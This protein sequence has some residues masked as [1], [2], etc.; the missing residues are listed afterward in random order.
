[1]QYIR[2][3]RNINDHFPSD[4]ENYNLSVKEL[5]D[6]LLPL[7]FVDLHVETKNN[8]P[9]LIPIYKLV[10]VL[11]IDLVLR[12]PDN[13]PEVAISFLCYRSIDHC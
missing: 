3:S 10:D 11:S 7:D 5:R 9:V 12:V 4:M 1:M 13:F 8:G 6:L 2:C